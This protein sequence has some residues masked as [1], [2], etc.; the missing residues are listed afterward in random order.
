MLGKGRKRRRN[1][2]ERIEGEKK[3]RMERLLEKGRVTE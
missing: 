1:E 3:A 2:C